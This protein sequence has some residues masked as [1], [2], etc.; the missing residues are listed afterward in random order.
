MIKWKIFLGGQY[1]TKKIDI[2]DYQ[3]P[4]IIRID[5]PAFDETGQGQSFVNHPGGGNP[6]I[7][8]AW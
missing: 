1:L 5:D 8:P 7:G 4:E 3:K 2:K 6:P